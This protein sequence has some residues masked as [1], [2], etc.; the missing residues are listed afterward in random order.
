MSSA[1]KG[2]QKA[3]EA[4]RERSTT[5]DYEHPNE[6]VDTLP[7]YEAE[8]TSNHGRPDDAEMSDWEKDGSE[9]EGEYVKINVD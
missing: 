8:D 2:K 7:R 1:S 5:L 9:D 3:A 4:E 6:T